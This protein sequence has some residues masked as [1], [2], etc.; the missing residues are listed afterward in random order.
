[1]RAKFLFVPL[2]ILGLVSITN[3]QSADPE[4]IEGKV[5]IVSDGDELRVKTTAG[6]TYTIKILG[7]D[8]PEK[9]QDYGTA[10]RKDLESR[11]LDKDVKIVV[12]RKDSE[13]RYMGT[14]FFEGQDIGVRMLENGSAWHYK[15]VSGEQSSEARVRYAKAELKAREAKVGLWAAAIPM[16]PWEFREEVEDGKATAAMP[17]SKAIAPAATV[18]KEEAQQPSAASN[19]DHSG[20]KYMLGPRGG[21]YYLNSSGGKVYVKDKTLCSKP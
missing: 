14:V 21:C 20:K 15:R 8:A 16:P 18:T 4:F 1:M 10:A 19:A 3:A 9:G 13:G 6:V 7:I 17:E 5:I 2:V 12:H 11:V